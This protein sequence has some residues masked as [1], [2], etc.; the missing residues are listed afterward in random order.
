GGPFDGFFA[1]FDGQRSPAARWIGTAGGDI[2]TTVAASPFGGA[3]V[4]GQTDSSLWGT[5]YNG[6]ASDGFV[7]FLD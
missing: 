1:K 3:Y 4:G 6:G 7:T 2:S 5:T